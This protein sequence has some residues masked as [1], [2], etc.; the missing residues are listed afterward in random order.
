MALFGYLYNG[1][2]KNLNINS[3]GYCFFYDSPELPFFSVLVAMFDYLSLVEN[4]YVDAWA[5][6]RCFQSLEIVGNNKGEV[7][8]CSRFVPSLVGGVLNEEVSVGDVVTTNMFTALSAWVSNADD[9]AYIQWLPANVGGMGLPTM[10]DAVI[11]S[12]ADTEEITVSMSLSPNPATAQVRIVL[13]DG[14]ESRIAE[15]FSLDGRLVLSATPKTNVIDISNLAAGM[16]IVKV[17]TENGES[18]EK[19]IV[20]E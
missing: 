12:I 13:P 10:E 15:V 20:K 11:C 9:P 19:K 17:T 6:D 18:F 2:V 8:N 14:V 3:C 5:G 7:A 4:C 1:T 16:Y